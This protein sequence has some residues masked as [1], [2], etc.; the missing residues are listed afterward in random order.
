MAV[1]VL[2][3]C[4]VRDLARDTIIFWGVA[5][6]HGVA[7]VLGDVGSRT[8]VEGVEFGHFSCLTLI[9][10]ELLGG[11]LCLIIQQSAPFD[12]REI[13]ILPW[14]RIQRLLCRHKWPWSILHRTLI[15]NYIMTSSC[16]TYLI[17]NGCPAVLTRHWRIF[18]F[19]CIYRIRYHC[20]LIPVDLR[21]HLTLPRLTNLV[22]TSLHPPLLF[23]LLRISSI[24]HKYFR[25]LLVARLTLVHI[26]RHS[27]VIAA[28]CLVVLRGGLHLI[29][30]LI[31]KVFAAPL[32]FISCFL[33]IL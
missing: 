29:P 7:L 23:W 12:L 1:H 18:V 4:G 5:V 9:R 24:L 30:E 33:G 6:A 19:E 11:S 14:A 15:R 26:C 32:R 25:M 21:T 2:D 13:L 31:L 8:L 3:I 22:T 20:S 16:Y 28:D 27:A 17:M 10:L